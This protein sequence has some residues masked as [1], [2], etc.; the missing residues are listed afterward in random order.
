MKTIDEIKHETELPAVIANHRG[1]ITF[2]NERFEEAFGWRNNEI[3]GKPLTVIIPQRLHDSHHL[4]F[5]RFV[6]TG[7]PTL[8][9]KPLKLKA[10]T[11]EGQEFDSEHVIIAEQQQGEWIFGA[12]IQPCEKK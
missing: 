10:I 1:L 11:K 4:G 9:N 7:K 8:L 3:I 6:M 2:V 12:T 5:S